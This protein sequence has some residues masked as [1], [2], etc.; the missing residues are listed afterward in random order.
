[1][2][3]AIR[4]S[5]T[6]RAAYGVLTLGGIVGIIAASLPWSGDLATKI[7]AIASPAA[8]LVSSL[9][10]LIGLA[11][12]GVATL[13]SPAAMLCLALGIYFGVGA[14]LPALGNDLLVALLQVDYP[15]TL[16]E[17]VVADRV[18]AIGVTSLAG[19]AW[20]FLR[21]FPPADFVVGGNVDADYLRRAAIRLLLVG[22][23]VRFLITI[24][25]A[26]GAQTG[27]VPNSIA[28]LEFLAYLGLIILTYGVARGL[29]DRTTDRIVLVI[30]GT[31]NVVLSVVTLSKLQFFFAF[32]SVL[33]GFWMGRPRA[34]VLISIA[35]V[36]MLIYPALQQFISVGRSLTAVSSGA[37]LSE[38]L[39]SIPKANSLASEI[40]ADEEISGRTTARFSY[41]A[42]SV[43]AIR[44]YDAGLPGKSMSENI[45]WYFVPRF[46]W[47]AKPEMTAASKEVSVLMLG[48]DETRTGL[49]VFAEGYW[50]G[51]YWLTVIG[52]ALVGIVLALFEF[53]RPRA[54]ATFDIPWMYVFW[55][56]CTEAFAIDGFFLP[57][58]F[59]MWPIVIGTFVLLRLA[60]GAPRQ[61][62][63]AAP[64]AATAPA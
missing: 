27:F 23:A 24:P 3:T 25:Y 29:L 52:P 63:S 21:A 19:A 46:I 9:I 31:V 39:E 6:T 2:A 36:G 64:I 51:G 37:S 40:Y 59:G 5:Q 35:V 4:S 10:A 17:T 58:Y 53:W 20:I 41:V 32:G 15:Y 47:P 28:S 34:R 60:F 22:T 1:M 44:S 56:G 48:T 50:N 14:L 57:Q 38:R 42:A 30:F 7:A 62:G 33:A 11:R 55:Y 16:A 49:G 13:A 45:L 43:F 61:A 18:T 12:G 8:I 54:L 26:L